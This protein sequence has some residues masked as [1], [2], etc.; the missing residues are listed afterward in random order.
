MQVA[1]PK[2]LPSGFGAEAKAARK[3]VCKERGLTLHQFAKEA[4]ISVPHLRRIEVEEV[5]LLPYE[6]FHKLKAAL[7]DEFPVDAC[8]GDLG[9]PRTHEQT[10]FQQLVQLIWEALKT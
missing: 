2:D 8:S 9:D 5:E 7:G 10:D 4:G 6:T 1:I 3:R